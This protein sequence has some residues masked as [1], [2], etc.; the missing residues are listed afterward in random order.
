MCLRNISWTRINVQLVTLS[1]KAARPVKNLCSVYHARVILF[2]WSKLIISAKDATILSHIVL[3]AQTKTLAQ[4]ANLSTI[5]IMAIVNRVRRYQAASSAILRDALS[6]KRVTTSRQVVVC[7]V[8]LS[9]LIA[10][11]VPK[12]SALSAS[13]TTIFN[14]Q[15][16]VQLVRFIIS[17]V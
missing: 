13:L 17:N 8:L 16:S 9:S 10:A 14:R 1:I 2:T 4:V 5:W 7:F 11:C 6:V 12:L 15:I 3:L